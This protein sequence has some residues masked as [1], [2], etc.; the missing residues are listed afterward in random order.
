MFFNCL[1]MMVRSYSKN[2]MFVLFSWQ[3][4]VYNKQCDHEGWSSMMQVTLNPAP[5]ESSVMPG[6]AYQHSV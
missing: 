3:V 4:C 5:S 1:H 6:Y 2:K